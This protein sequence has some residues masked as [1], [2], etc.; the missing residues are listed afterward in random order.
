MTTTAAHPAAALTTL[1]S[2]GQALNHQPLRH[3]GRRADQMRPITLETGVNAYAE[4]SCL[5]TLGGTKVL[6]TASVEQAV[7]KFL[8]KSGKGW[9]SAE[10]G[11]LP[12][13]THTRTD[14]EASKGKQTGRTQEIQRLIGRALRA[15]VDTSKLGECTI[16][17]DCDVL[18]ADGGTRCASI[19]GAYVAL[20]GQL[21]AISSGLLAD[22]QPVLD[23]SY[24]EDSTALADANFVL[25]RTGDVVE[26][27][28]TAEAA[29][30][31]QEKLHTMLALAQQGVA[32]LCDLQNQ[33][34]QAQ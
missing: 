23:L 5:I 16:W 18:Q 13:A 17:L 10:Y 8:H 7:P 32:H 3:D 26:V 14:R 20:A 28:C 34:I 21:A 22:G 11:L 31:A 25:T 6:C 27:Q 19:T 12:R 15:V 24:T 2:L 29:P 30:I 33:A 1:N 4:G 9:V